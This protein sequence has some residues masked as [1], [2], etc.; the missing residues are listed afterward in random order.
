[1][2]PFSKLKLIYLLRRQPTFAVIR[3][4]SNA[5][6][7]TITEAESRVPKAGKREDV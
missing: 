1:L 7:D 4:V 2:R 6:T 3:K 5:L